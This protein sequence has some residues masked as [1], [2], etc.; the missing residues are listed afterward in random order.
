MRPLSLVSASV[1]TL[2]AVGTLSVPSSATAPSARKTQATKVVGWYPAPVGLIKGGYTTMSVRVKSNGKTWKRTVVLQRKKR[3]S[4]RKV[5]R[6]RT[7]KTG[8]TSLILRPPTK[9]AFKYRVKVKPSRNAKK[10]VTKAKRVF[11]LD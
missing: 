4:W 10:K 6:K 2:R 5:D 11:V 7:T 1:A 3:G 8:R 9:G